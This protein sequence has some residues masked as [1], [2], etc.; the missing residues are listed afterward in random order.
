M[1]EEGGGWQSQDDS[2]EEEYPAGDGWPLSR[3][4][5]HH[6]VEEE[7]EEEVAH[8]DEEQEAGELLDAAGVQDNKHGVDEEKEADEDK[9]GTFKSV[10]V[11]DSFCSRAAI[12][13]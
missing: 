10:L 8:E 9:P 5:L 12:L 7:I 4:K 2:K 3:D 11:K 6:S 13:S 1:A